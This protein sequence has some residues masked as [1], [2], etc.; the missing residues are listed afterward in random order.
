MPAS[1]G[2]PSNAEKIL[3]AVAGKA[4]ARADAAST[5]GAAPT[6]PAP[7]S[8]WDGAEAVVGLG[9]ELVVAIRNNIT[10]EDV[11][12]VAGWIIQAAVGAATKAGI[13][14]AAGGSDG[15]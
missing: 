13:E 15:R 10:A 6:K 2:M 12:T 14:R 9:V 5:S 4:D 3:A 11:A 1:D 7:P 8:W